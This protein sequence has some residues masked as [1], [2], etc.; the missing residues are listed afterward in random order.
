M[1]LEG[2]TLLSS[3]TWTVDSPGETGTG[4]GNSG[5]LTYCIDQADKTAGQNTIEFSAAVGAIQ[6]TKAL[7]DL[8]NSSGDPIQTI[9]I[10]GG[11]SGGNITG[12][13][14]ASSVLQV[15]P[16][17]NATFRGLG[18]FCGV[19]NVGVSNEGT[20]SISACGI[21]GNVDGD[22]GGVI[23]EGTLSM[24]SC[25]ISAHVCEFDETEG[26]GVFNDAGATATLDSCAISGN[27]VEAY[28]NGQR[29]AAGGGLFNR[30]TLSMTGCTVSGNTAEPRP[31]G[32]DAQYGFGGGLENDGSA[33][34]TSCTFSG[35]AAT[36]GQGGGV[37]N[38]GAALT[39]AATLTLTNCTISGN[40]AGRGA[41][42]Y[43][44]VTCHLNVTSCTVSGNAA[45]NTG[46]GLQNRGTA[47]VINTIIAGN[48]D[49]F[50]GDSTSDYDGPS[51]TGENDLVGGN[52]LLA[53]LGYYGGQAETM[54]LL[55][56]SPAI[57]T[58]DRGLAG[59]AD[60][61]GYARGSSVDIGAYQD[62]G[63]TLTAVAGS[64][65][66]AAQVG[67]T[68]GSSLA[69]T[70][71]ANDTT[72]YTDPVDGGEVSFSA[73]TSGAT[74]SLSAA[75]AT[76][77]DGQ[78][79]VTATAGATT[80]PFTVTASAA[81]AA[82]PI[83]FKLTDLRVPSLV[84]DTTQDVVSDIG[85]NSLRDAIAYAETLP[86]PATIT[87]DPSVFPTGPA[88][89]PQTIT[90]NPAYGPLDLTVGNITIQGPGAD[91][92][93]IDCNEASRVFEVDL[94]VTASI[95]GLTITGGSTSSTGGG[96]YNLGALAL[97]DCTL[98][99]NTAVYG[100]SGL[101]NS[102]TATLTDCTLSGNTASGRY[103]HD[104]ALTNAYGTVTLTDCTISGNSGTKG[105][106]LYNEVGTFT[107]TDCTVSGNSAL[108]V[109]GGLYIRA[110]TA[111]LTN[112]IVAENGGGDVAGDYS[113]SN[114]LIGGDPLLAPLGDYGGPT[115]T[116]AL[117][118]GS[119]AIGGGDA[120][121]APATDQRGLPRFGPTDIGAFEYQ[122]KVTNTNASGLG[123]LAQAVA[124][125]N[126]MPGAATVIVLPAVTGTIDLD[127]VPLVLSN[128]SGTEAID[129]PGANQLAVSGGDASGV[130]AIESGVT[131]SISGLTI[132]GGNTTFG[133]GVQNEGTATLTDCT[134]S[135]NSAGGGGGLADS[136]FATATLTDCT[137]SGNSVS[138][139]GGVFN[140][141][142]ATLI[143]CTFSANSASFS[144]GG[145]Y[146][147][148]GVNNGS[149]AMFTD[150]TVSGNSASDGGGVYN[151]STATLIDCTVQQ[152][153]RQ[154]RRWRPVQRRHGHSDQHDR[155]RQ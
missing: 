127:G 120:A 155:R 2:R 39:G 25:T 40:A 65:P 104:G 146:N 118:P 97:T 32:F 68:F 59:T 54:A 119:P 41:G 6:L 35:N 1:A 4:S 18:I 96:M 123:S 19:G 34:L 106:G 61:R 71:T 95:S 132:T 139:G 28:L 151:R 70:V 27:L 78:A 63:F 60:Q 128:T 57:G 11:P 49:E 145:V 80:G 22:G 53:P 37:D 84:V 64:T 48:A 46:G 79:S 75:T 105:G 47:T 17:V 122:L 93:T 69:V 133:G 58:G 55:P 3:T 153:L 91:L 136:Y 45:D 43:N 147:G 29:R 9:T 148:G 126:G 12:T 142:T 154:Q 144:G 14:T 152:Q 112:T 140:Q 50:N 94:G 107:L 5:D 24:T 74:A 149:T 134:L 81:G 77:T 82:Q 121:L 101:V 73:P 141:G 110:G 111:T 89:T 92:L 42:L 30:G 102:G 44:R 7:P 150:C 87:F 129:G 13:P 131:A 21:I 125:A 72:E 56:G 62:Q 16:G 98:S 52:P 124:N 135:G 143:G 86:G 130:F 90:L 31:I 76:I 83:S 85:P 20:L 115:Q 10:L 26:A 113:G 15:D 33:T 109:V 8:E 36:E 23:N 99:G 51:G 103:G 114:D 108:L 138:F 38:G 66:Q 117:L 67:A 116:M 88:S 137:L 100:G